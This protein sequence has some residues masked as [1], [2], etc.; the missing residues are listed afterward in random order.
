VSGP[1][2]L[3]P[4][5]VASTVRRLRISKPWTLAQF[6]S[7][8]PCSVSTAHR[9]EVLGQ[10]SER[11]WARAA[12]VLGVAVDEIRGEV[13]GVRE[14]SADPRQLPL[15]EVEVRTWAPEPARW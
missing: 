7:E 12:E 13:H 14:N 4:D 9:L 8:I 5:D 6:A 1:R 3:W 10:G 15:L 11:L 2:R